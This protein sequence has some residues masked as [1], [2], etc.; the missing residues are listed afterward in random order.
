MDRNPAWTNFVVQND[1]KLFDPV[2]YH[3]KPEERHTFQFTDQL[4][5]P[6]SLRIYEAHVGMSSEHGRVTQYREFADNVLPHIKECGY[7]CVQ[8]MAI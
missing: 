2:F 6:K 3:P 7:N 4:K 5:Q 1:T 8:L